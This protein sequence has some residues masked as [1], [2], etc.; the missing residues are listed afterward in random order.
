MQQ[1]NKL[2]SV[3][4]IKNR[5]D[6]EVGDVVVGRI[7]EVQQKRWKVDTNSRLDS[8]LLLSSVDLPGRELVMSYNLIVNM[9]LIL[10]LILKTLMLMMLMSNSG[11]DRNY[12]RA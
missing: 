11:Q 10:E 2:I 8:V 4:P 12:W 3:Q 6:G 7:T 5:Y 1:V 9:I